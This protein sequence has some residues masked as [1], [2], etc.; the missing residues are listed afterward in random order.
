MKDSNILTEDAWEEK[1]VPVINHIE[2]AK[3]D[4][5]V[6][7]ED[8]CGWNGWLYETYGK[9]LEYIVELARHSK[10]VWTIIEGDD[11]TLYYTAGYH[12]VNRLG[13][14]VTENPWVTGE[15]EVELD[16][17]FA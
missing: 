16:N 11:D 1:Y 13:Y 17:D 15:E 14:I 6:A 3:Q 9:D 2:R 8:L 12:L 4:S 5:S 7:D 10:R